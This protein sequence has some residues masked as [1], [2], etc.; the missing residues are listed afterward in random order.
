MISK[1][2]SEAWK[3]A[4]KNSKHLI[5][6][7]LNKILKNS[8]QDIRKAGKMIKENILPFV[9]ALSSSIEKNYFLKKISDQSGISENALQ[10]DLKKIEQELK[11]EK[12]EINENKETVETL[13]KKDYI[14]RKLLGIALWK[15]DKELEK[16]L[17]QILE[18]YKDTGNDLIFEAEVFYGN[19]DNL[20]KDIR[21]LLA[22]LEEEKINEDLSRK[23]QEL[24]I[25]KD[26][27]RERELLSAIQ[28]LNKQKH[29]KKK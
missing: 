5:E 13:R 12:T 19:S 4:I 9:N 2:G 27:D 21:E 22:N 23:M 24:R 28:N 1:R 29:E 25:V 3:E 11:S 26:K 15:K 20:E 17:G 7:L 14:E 10:D 16:S 6:F 8:G 18:K